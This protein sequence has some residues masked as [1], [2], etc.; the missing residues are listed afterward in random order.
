MWPRV[1][2]A[3]GG[4][5][6]RILD[7]FSDT[8]LP[9][10]QDAIR[11]QAEANIQLVVSTMSMQYAQSGTVATITPR[12]LAQFE[13]SMTFVNGETPS[14]DPRV[15]SVATDATAVTAAIAAEGGICAFAR[16]DQDA[17]VST[18]T[19]VSDNACTAASA[20]AHGWSATSGGGGGG[21]GFGVD[22]E[23][24]T[25]TQPDL[26]LQAN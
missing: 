4:G 26:G 1:G 2:V 14:G 11:V 21:L 6:V 8:A 24:L 5:D 13:P 3:S 23:Q 25:P 16:F 15:V 20:P 12:E 22:P 18:V 19:T 9:G 10:V 7:A 17:Q